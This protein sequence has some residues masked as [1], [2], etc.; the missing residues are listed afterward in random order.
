M[1][2]QWVQSKIKTT[3]DTDIEDNI[4]SN[5]VFCDTIYP[6]KTD[7][8]K[9]Y[10][11][12]CGHLP[13]IPNKRNIYIHVM[14]VWYFF[15]TLMNTMNNVSDQE[16]VRYFNELTTDQKTVFSLQDSMS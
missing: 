10:L 2:T 5:L 4:K 11:E 15:A 6:S 3:Q 12:S 14:Y 1:N 16:M 13:I 7:E 8:G 9:I